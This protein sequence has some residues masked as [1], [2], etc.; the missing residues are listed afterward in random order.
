MEVDMDKQEAIDMLNNAVDLIQSLDG[1]ED[2]LEK[3]MG[4]IDQA[5]DLI[6]KYAVVE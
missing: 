4:H 3:A 1:N 2:A 6:V 5:I